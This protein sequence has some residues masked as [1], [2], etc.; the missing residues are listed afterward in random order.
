MMH[1]AYSAQSRR[2]KGFLLYIASVSFRQSSFNER[3][4]LTTWPSLGKDTAMIV[5]DGEKAYAPRS[6]LAIIITIRPFNPPS[7]TAESETH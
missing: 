2:H 4:I 3:T 5:A 6:T 1:K 7:R